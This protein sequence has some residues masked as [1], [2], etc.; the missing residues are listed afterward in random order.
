MSTKRVSS[1]RKRRSTRAVSSLLVAALAAVALAACATMPSEGRV[2][3]GEGL[4]VAPGDVGQIADGPRDGA[5]PD[6]IVRGFLTA[7][8]AGPTMPVAGPTVTMTVPFSVANEYLTDA[9]RSQWRPLSQVMIVSTTPRVG[10]PD[11]LRPGVDHATV[12]V[13]YTVVAS[14]DESGTLIEQATPTTQEI[15][16]DVV[17]EYDGAQWRIATV[18]DLLL[19]PAQLFRSAFHATYLHFPTPDNAHW[20]TDLR[21]FPQQTWRTNAVLELLDGPP[22]WLIGAVSNPLPAGTS[23]AI[24]SVTVDDDGAVTIPLSDHV[25]RASAADRALFSA[26]VQATLASGVARPRIILEDRFGP[27]AAPEDIDLPT[28][29]RTVGAALALHNNRLWNVVDRRLNVS[30]YRPNLRGLTPTALAVG[31]DPDLELVVMVVEGIDE[32]EEPEPCDPEGDYPCEYLPEDDEEPDADAEPDA[33][34]QVANSRLMRVESEPSTLIEGTDL[35]APSIDRFSTIWTADAYEGLLAVDRFG[36][37]RQVVAAWLVDR[38]VVSVSVAPDGARIAIVSTGAEGTVI[39]VAGI[40][41]DL[42]GNPL[43]LAAPIEVG[44]RVFGDV[45]RAVWQDETVLAVLAE[46]PLSGVYLVGVGG[47]ADNEGG[48]TRKLSDITNVSWLTASVGTGTIIALDVANQLHLHQQSP[49]WS[50]SSRNVV[51]VAFPG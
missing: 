32:I 51:L 44:H 21:W 19:V 42:S 48:L 10:Q 8:Q 5:E 7:A 23:L 6:E 11:I 41:R 37:P 16:F 28:D 20:V 45:A 4:E 22:R 15:I 34:P 3:A 29:A 24:A 30:G 18:P 26:Q 14:L 33:D 43:S 39:H 27:F 35:I 12:T 47:L 46:G 40:S 25:E 17:R 2:Q 31:P 50:A 49:V 9:A 13:T 1:D 36:N 38:Q